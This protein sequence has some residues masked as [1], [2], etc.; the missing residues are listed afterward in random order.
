[1]FEIWLIRH[2]ESIANAGA[3]TQNHET[4]PLSRRRQ[5]Q[6]PKISLLFPCQPDLIITSL[7]TRTMQTAGPTLKRFPWARHE[8]W[9]VQEFT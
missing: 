5:E 7:F 2:G 6:A 4:I 3:A 8:V 9:E 1:M